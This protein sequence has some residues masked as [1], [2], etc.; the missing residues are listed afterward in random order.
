MFEKMEIRWR[1]DDKIYMVIK[2]S[3]CYNI[4]RQ[5]ISEERILMILGMLFVSIM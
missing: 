2:G 5:F 3:F 4:I 1:L